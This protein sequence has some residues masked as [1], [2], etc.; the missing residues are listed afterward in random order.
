MKLEFIIPHM[1]VEQTLS[2]RIIV[3]TLKLN[4]FFQKILRVERMLDQSVENLREKMMKLNF[5]NFDSR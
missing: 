1:F 4:D 3:A 5:K 2:Y